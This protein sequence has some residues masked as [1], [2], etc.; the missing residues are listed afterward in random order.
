MKLPNTLR[1][2][3]ALTNPDTTNLSRRAAFKGLATVGVPVAT[4]AL[5]PTSLR[6][7][8]SGTSVVDVLNFALT[9]EYLEAEF[10]AMGLDADGLLSGELRDKI[11]LI[12]DHEAD[13]VEFLRSAISGAGGEPIDSPEFDFTA[14]G[15]FADVFSN[16]ATFLALAQA[17]EDTGVRAYKGQAGNLMGSGDVLT[18]ALQ[19][20]SVEARHASEIRRIRGSRGW[21]VE[22]DNT[23]AP[24]AE[25]VYAGE[26]NT[27]H[28]GLDVNTVTS[29]S[30]AQITAAYDEPLSREAV[31]DI[32]GL[33]LA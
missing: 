14:G 19:I 6:A 17:F 1:Q 21:I 32:A 24:A 5:A 22:A 27:T 26:D 15:T 28:L 30:S 8:S 23:S 9:L 20:H 4:A 12:G 25:A 16:E 18:A 2:L 31:L 7:Q 10:Y 13:H 11:A 3:M 29:A 33:F